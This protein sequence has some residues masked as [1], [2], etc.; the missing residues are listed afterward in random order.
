[1]SPRHDSVCPAFGQ[2]KSPCTAGASCSVAERESVN[3]QALCGFQPRYCSNPR[4]IPDK[5]DISAHRTAVK[6]D[7]VQLELVP[8]NFGLVGKVDVIFLRIVKRTH[9]IRD[10]GHVLAIHH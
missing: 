7:F 10:A 4:S 2:Q 8:P 6:L 9:P 1:M 3:P 5:P